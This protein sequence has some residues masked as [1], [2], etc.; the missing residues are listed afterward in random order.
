[1]VSAHWFPLFVVIIISDI[2]LLPLIVI[3][4]LFLSLPTYIPPW[5]VAQGGPC[6]YWSYVGLGIQCMQYIVQLAQDA[7][8][9]GLHMARR[10]WV[11]EVACLPVRL[12]CI[13]FCAVTLQASCTFM[14]VVEHVFCSATRHGFF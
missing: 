13:S 14:L 5:D 12:Q 1:M 3:V 8:T 4:L 11:K 7:L 9:K 10:G 6:M 2:V